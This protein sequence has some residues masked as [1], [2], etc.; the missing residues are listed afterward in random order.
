MTAPPST[1]Q[2]ESWP[3]RK[4][5]P[6]RRSLPLDAL[7]TAANGAE[8]RALLSPLGARSATRI[9]ADELRRLAVPTLMV[10]GYRDPVV[11]VRE[12]RAAAE[13]IANA[14]LEVLPGGHVPQL[15]NPARVAELLT[16]FARQ[17]FPA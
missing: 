15:G 4:P 14:R 10:W 8:F 5:I 2:T 6:P 9:R 12:A 17:G 16:G 7:A 3:G 1:S 11:P 13:L